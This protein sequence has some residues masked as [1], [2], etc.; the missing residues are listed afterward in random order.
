MS[1][2][3]QITIVG[4][5]TGDPELRFI[6]SGQA[7]ANFTIASNARKFNKDTKEWTDEPANFWRCNAWRDMAENVAE[8][9]TKGMGVIVL[10][11]VKSRPWETKEGEKR[12]SLEVEVVAVGPDLRWAT[13]K[14]TKAARGQGNGAGQPVTR[15]AAVDPW[16]QA[17]VEAPF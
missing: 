17:N 7:V 13:A 10:G 1:N 3:Q 2:E 16:G 9:L 5:L 4:R 14:V 6:Q 15:S 12:T 8:S 11:E